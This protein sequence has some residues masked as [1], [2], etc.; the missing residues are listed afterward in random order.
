MSDRRLVSA[1]MCAC[2]CGITP[3][4]LYAMARAGLVPSYRVG[5]QRRG[6]RF[7]VEEVKEALRR[8]LDDQDES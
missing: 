1:E 8:D 6:V 7:D 5:V 3:G 2:A 4:C